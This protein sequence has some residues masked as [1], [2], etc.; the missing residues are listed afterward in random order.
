MVKIYGVEWKTSEIEE[1]SM[2]SLG[3][4]WEVKDIPIKLINWKES[5][6]N[7]ARAKRAYDETRMQCYASFMRSDKEDKEKFP[8]GIVT[9]Q[10]DKYVIVSGVHRYRAAVIASETLIKTYVVRQLNATEFRTLA[11]ACNLRTGL[12]LHPDDLLE[13]VVHLVDKGEMTAQEA[14]KQYECLKANTI[15][16]RVKVKRIKRKAVE[17]GAS[18]G[19]ILNDSQAAPL[20]KLEWN[21]KVLAA[22]C[23]VIG[24]YKIVGKDASIFVSNI[25]KEDDESDQL[26]FIATEEAK[27]IKNTQEG[28]ARILSMPV[29][30]NIKRGLNT[31]LNQLQ[32]RECIEDYQFIEGTDEVEEFRANCRKLIQSLERIIRKPSS[33]HSKK[34]SGN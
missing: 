34:A 17:A 19:A 28:N 24:K 23:T 22:A 13:Q 2:K 5:Q 7:P 32:G 3:L 15:T 10:D 9:R 18:Q 33:G 6:D 1:S 20:V 11:M 25:L 14:V 30:A 16:G 12:G 26:A 27:L 4:T 21:K 31:L 29:K 8:M